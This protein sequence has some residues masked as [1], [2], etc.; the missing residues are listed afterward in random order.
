MAAQVAATPAG[1]L[2][3]VYTTPA[4]RQA[5][6]KLLE[7]GH[8]LP[9][10]LVASAAEAAWERA[11]Q[12]DETCV[13]V[14]VDGSTLTLPS[15]QAGDGK[16]YGPVGTRAQ[17]AVG[18]EALSAV[19]LS[20]RGGVPLGVVGQVLW[21]RPQSPSGLSE[22][23]RRARPLEEKETRYWVQVLQEATDSWR[24]SPLRARPWF[25]L[26]AGADAREVL[27]WAAWTQ[28][29]YVTVRSAQNRCLEFPREA[30]LKTTVETLTPGGLMHVTVPGSAKRLRR[31]AQ[32]ELRFSP[33]VVSLRHPS[34]GQVVPVELFAVHAREVGSCPGHEEPIEWLL[35]TNRPVHAVKGARQVLRAYARRWRVEEVHRSWKSGCRVEDSG[36][37]FEPFCLWATLLFC[38]AVRIERLKLLARDS[39]HLPASSEFSRH[40]I[41]ALLLLKRKGPLYAQGYTPTLLEA[42]TWVAE[43]GGYT[44]KSSGG[45]PGA[46]TLKRGL[47]RLTPAAET[48]RLQEE[49][50]K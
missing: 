2:T 20:S 12:R 7:K 18:V 13:L 43:L 41:A 9:Q 36:L 34:S 27:E 25:Q 5:A 10:A 4:D 17:R 16:G 46:T 31:K 40:E 47:D 22:S 44:G 1:R 3:E 15:A 30:L 29:A 21:T 23:A 32:L 26:D 50:A 37:G 28:E 33:V 6:Y 49:L 19:A 48:L 42:I 35:L 24:Q 39:P 45:P 8:V 38:V 14:A 11:R